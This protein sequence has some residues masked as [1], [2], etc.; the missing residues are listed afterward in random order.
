MCWSESSVIYLACRRPLLLVISITYTPRLVPS[1]PLW[2]EGVL[3][4]LELL[5]EG[6]FSKLYATVLFPL[7][8][9]GGEVPQ[10]FY[11]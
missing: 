9:P 3:Q 5:F 6:N 11:Q 2:S 1:C 10:S 8:P 4:T 7:A